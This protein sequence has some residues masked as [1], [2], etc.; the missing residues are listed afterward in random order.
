MIYA[1]DTAKYNEENEKIIRN[2]DGN[3]Y[4]GFADIICRYS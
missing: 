4:R 2:F 1:K 3:F